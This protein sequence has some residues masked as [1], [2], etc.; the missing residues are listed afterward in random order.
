MPTIGVGI[1]CYKPHLG[2]LV[3]LLE[4]LELQSRK[5]DT[6][7]ISSSS[8]LP[9][10]VP[11]LGNYSFPIVMIL[12]SEKRKAAE[13]R[14][15]CFRNITCDLLSFVD[16]DDFC[17]PRRLEFIETAYLQG[18]ELI[19]HSL[20]ENLAAPW[21]NLDGVP[22]EYD[23]L[24]RGPTGCLIHKH[25]RVLINH[26]HCSVAKELMK[27]IQFG[28]TAHY[29]RRED[30]LFCGEIIQIAG[31]NAFINAALTKYDK[32]GTAGIG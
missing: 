27:S 5:P 8:T 28:T 1:P 24:A 30:S 20:T 23:C 21:Q 4:S 22:I 2:K 9:E 18:A 6:V 32:S 12:D 17:H 13:N 10:D 29:D 11:P 7:V 26:G 25:A 19:I 14:N 15:I 31:K 3:R 16:A